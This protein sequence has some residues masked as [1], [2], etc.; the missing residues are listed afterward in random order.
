MFHCHESAIYRLR[1]VMLEDNQAVGFDVPWGG[2]HASVMRQ[3]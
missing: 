1:V 2:H 3:K